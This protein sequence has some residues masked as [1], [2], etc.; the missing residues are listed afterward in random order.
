MRCDNTE[1]DEAE[2]GYEWGGDFLARGSR[3]RCYLPKG[4]EGTCECVCGSLSRW[5]AFEGRRSQC[6]PLP[7]AKAAANPLPATGRPPV[8]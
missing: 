8:T 4:H 7:L 1:Q 6:D 2:C 5:Q 3:H